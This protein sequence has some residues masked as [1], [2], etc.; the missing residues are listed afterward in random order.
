[1]KLIVGIGNPGLK[2][3]NT[4]HNIGFRVLDKFCEGNNLKLKPAKGEYWLVESMI[5]TFHFFLMKPSTYV[6][7]SGIAIKEFILKENINVS[8]IL[9]IYDDT[10]LKPGNLRI[11]KTGSDGGHNGI[12]SII[13]HLENDQF[14]RIRIGVG[15]P[16]ANQD[17]A[18]YVLSNF[19]ED[20]LNNIEMNFPFIM[21]LIEKFIIGGTND[22]LNFYS[23]ESKDR[24]SNIT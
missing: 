5:D 18:D 4:R 8:D 15:N 14:T 6:N 21:Q 10:N 1:M 22:M 9:V 24:S 2:Y 3:K 16:N 23:I 20:E 13:Y 19:P 17:L 7:N 11:R 12:K